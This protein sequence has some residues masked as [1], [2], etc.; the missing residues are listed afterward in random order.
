MNTVMQLFSKITVSS[1]C[2]TKCAHWWQIWFESIKLPSTIR[3]TNQFGSQ[4]IFKHHEIK[5]QFMESWSNK[6][7]FC[8]KCILLLIALENNN[9][10]SQNRQA[11]IPKV[12]FIFFK[13][14]HNSNIVHIMIPRE[15]ILS[16]YISLGFE[17]E[18][19]P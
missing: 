19:S 8:S 1:L 9:V 11:H 16:K 12:P 3:K 10:Q 13:P 4:E 5:L 14:I 15:W 18:Q 17:W 7:L 2:A 6:I